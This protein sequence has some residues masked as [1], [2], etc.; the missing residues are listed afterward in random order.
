MK[1]RPYVIRWASR[2]LILAV[3]LFFVL[4]GPLPVRIAR[5]IP[6]SSPLALAAASMAQRGWAA[7]LFWLLPPLALLAAALWKGRFFCRW[8]CP[9]GTLYA[10][11][12]QLHLPRKLIFR[13][14][15]NALLFWVIVSSSLL[16]LPLL[17][18]LDP[19][20]TFSRAGV[21][22]EAAAW[23]PG[24]LIPLMLTISLFQ[25]Q[26]W[27]THLCP[28]GYLFD[29]AH[30]PSARRV[31]RRDRR[32]FLAGCSIGVPAALFLPGADRILAA[33]AIQPPGAVP[34]FPGRCSRCYAC[35]RACPTGII[36]VR[37]G[38]G[39][40]T[41]ALPV[42]S[43][44]HGSCAPDCTLCSQVCPVGALRPLHPGEKQQLQI[45]IAQVEKSRCLAWA[46][47]EFCMVCDE[48]CP[49]NAIQTVWQGD[50]ACPEVDPALCR[51][52]GACEHDCPAVRAGKAIRVAPKTP[53][54]QLAI[55]P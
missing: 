16:G 35:V 37:P 20:S 14:R 40:N 32:Q 36:R 34:A 45:G 28:L 7:A 33:P 18:F 43:F 25:P 12:G 2:L 50:T 10:L 1:A 54:A 38:S 24:L 17:L 47:D 11:P 21:W 39:I 51:G 9:L 4:G 5:L 53:Q 8:I 52:C 42:L 3:A 55:A 31:F 26:G 49:Y 13:V 48:V 46:D 44:D 15:Y 22:Y 19:L 41:A 23:I 6:A 29:L 27:C 30:L